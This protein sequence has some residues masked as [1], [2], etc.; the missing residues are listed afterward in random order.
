[1]NNLSSPL[2]KQWF[3]RKG[4]IESLME[5]LKTM[6]REGKT[7]LGRRATNCAYGLTG[8]SIKQVMGN[9]EQLPY[10]MRQVHK[11]RWNNTITRGFPPSVLGQE[12]MCIEGMKQAGWR[13]K[14]SRTKLG[15]AH[16]RSQK[17]FENAPYK[18]QTNG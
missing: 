7:R 13:M 2:H 4:L 9:K 8:T 11:Q 5:G 10:V 1:M 15:K 6:A 16:I 17:Q 3:K 14:E 18:L 12:N